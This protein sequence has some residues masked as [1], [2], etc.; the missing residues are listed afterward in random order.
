MFLEKFIKDGFYIING[1]LTNSCIKTAFEELEIAL[2][3]ELEHH[4]E[5]SDYSF[6]GYVLNNAYY[7]GIFLDIISEAPLFKLVELILGENMILYSYTSSSMPPKMGNASS[8]IHVDCPIWIKDYPLRVGVM[9]PLVDFTLEN[10][11]TTY[12]PGSH[13][14]EIKP[15]NETYLEHSKKLLV[16]A[17]SMF[18]FDARLWHSG[19]IN[20]TD[21]WRHAL[22]FNWC[23]PWMKQ[24]INMP[25]LLGSSSSLKLSSVAQK[26]LGYF[27]MPPE[28]YQEYFDKNKTRLFL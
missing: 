2:R 19:G 4:K 3:C 22:S 28:S 12:L 16:T 8:T 5:I 20:L 15:A 14:S 13:R 26:R 17:G 23:R 6:Y 1:V 9:I 21:Q 24:Y 27:S 18:I 7:G 11:A 10:G 25:K